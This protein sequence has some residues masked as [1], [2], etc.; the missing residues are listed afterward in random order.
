M[1]G[2]STVNRSG[3]CRWLTVNRQ[4][5]QRPAVVNQSVDQGIDQGADR[6][7][8]TVNQRDRGSATAELAVALPVL[9]LLLLAGLT[10]VSAVAT[11]LR[12]VDAAR[13]AARAEA[14]GE[15]GV[16]AGERV[17]PAG[18]VITINAEGDVVRAT[19]RTVVH[20]LG[21]R[22]PGMPVEAYT[23]AAREPDQAP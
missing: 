18:A 4:N 11:K 20:P 16:S 10:A 15:A 8:L 21:R 9:L 6:G 1:S 13:E 17:A 7:W 3:D 2:R 22:L 12:C 19:V 5:N 14:R 23:V